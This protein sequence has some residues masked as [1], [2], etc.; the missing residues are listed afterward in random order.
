MTSWRARCKRLLIKGGEL[1]EKEGVPR[2]VEALQSNVWT[3]MEFSTDNRPSLMAAAS[4]P[5]GASRHNGGGDV[6]VGSVSGFS[7]G[8]EGGTAAL[9]P[10]VGDGEQEVVSSRCALGLWACHASVFPGN[11]PVYSPPFCC[12][13]ELAESCCCEWRRVAPCGCCVSTRAAPS[14]FHSQVCLLW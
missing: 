10:S 7:T 11:A 9:S 1:R 14:F 12:A 5:P 3:G 2:I 8:G 6:G 13:Y 4:A